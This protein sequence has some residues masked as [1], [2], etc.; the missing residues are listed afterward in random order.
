MS[1]AVAELLLEWDRRQRNGPPVTPEELCAQRPEELDELRRRIGRLETCDRILGLTVSDHP[2]SEVMPNRIGDF[3]IRGQLGRGGMGVVYHGW[4]PGLKRAAAVKVL[5]PTVIYKPFVGPSELTTRF[6]REREVLGRL[7]HEHIVPVYGSG[8]SGGQPYV[9]MAMMAGGSLADRLDEMCRR[10]PRTAAAFVE[11]VARGVHAAHELGVLHRDLKPANI[12]LDAKGDPRVCDFGLA[13]FWSPDNADDGPSTCGRESE[14]RRSNQLTFPGFQPGTPAYMSPEQ[15]DVKI[16]RVGPATDVWALG[17]ILFEL[18]SGQRPF[19]ADDTTPLARQ[20]CQNVAPRCRSPHHRTPRWLQDVVSH[21][22][23]KDPEKR[24][25]SAAE[26]ANSLRAGLKRGRRRTMGIGIAA[27]L[28]L[29]L[30]AGFVGGRWAFARPIPTDVP[31]LAFVDRPDVQ[32]AVAD[33]TQGRQVVLV[34]ETRQAPYRWVFGSDTGRSVEREPGLLTLHTVW[35]GPAA[36]EFVP[37]LPPGKYRIRAVVRHDAGNSFSRVGLFAGG[38]Y[39]ES[40]QGRHLHCVA[41]HYGD[42][43]PEAA[44]PPPAGQKTNST[45]PL[46]TLLTGE[47]RTRPSHWDNNQVGYVEFLAA[48]AK[49]VRSDFRTLE[50]LLADSGVE[51]WWDGKRVGVVKLDHANETLHRARIGYPEQNQGNP[52][53]HPFWGSVGVF[54]FNGTMSVREFQITPVD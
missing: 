40:A 8:I 3:E 38:R 6:D 36:A 7:E 31:P 21:C 47:I 41:L 39:W 15:F 12:L 49:N 23:E 5:Q 25:T 28:L 37:N 18:I 11:K 20:V 1:P 19:A 17:V 4:D 44:L 53:P 48:A 33:L 24:Y 52:D 32:T 51:G 13:R 54:V 42:Q 43:G 22:L 9:A 35:S 27:T 34:D 45:A 2:V 10:G 26:L 16:G 46:C 30:V 50:F 29:V 14:G